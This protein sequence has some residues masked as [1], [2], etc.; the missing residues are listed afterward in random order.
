VIDRL[1][2]ASWRLVVATSALV[3]FALGS[4][5]LDA[6]LQELGTLACLATGLLYL[7]LAVVGIA[8][9]PSAWPWP[10]GALATVLL[11][12]GAAHVLFTDGGADRGWPLLQHVVTPVLV[13]ADI[14]WQPGTPGRWWWPL[15]WALLP[16][17]YFGYHR[18]TELA[19]YDALDPF[20]GDYGRTLAGLLIGVLVS[21]LLV[22]SLE[23]LRQSAYD[24]DIS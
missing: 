18:A 14:A 8:D 11:L 1:P 21:A 13:L 15:T 2:Q 6:P 4:A 22:Y 3:G 7:T 5:A 24:R 9:P 10:R 19:V 23:R 16:A 20:A 17:A 12:V